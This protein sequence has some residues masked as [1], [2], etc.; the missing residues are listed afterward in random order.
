MRI[1]ACGDA[2]FSSRNLLERMPKELVRLFQDADAVF[3]NAEFCCPRLTTAPMPRRFTTAVRPEVLDEFVALNIKLLSFANNHTGD[4]GIQGVIDTLEEA[5]VRKLIPGGIGRSLDEARA[6]HFIDTP[7]GRIGFLAAGST[8][9]M[10][11]AASNPGNGVPARAGLNPLRWGRSYVL[12]EKEFNELRHIDELLGTA[13][14]RR[15]V[16]AVEVMKPMPEDR[17]AFGSVFEGSLQIV[18]GDEAEVRYHMDERDKEAILAN[19]RDAANR[20]EIA[21]VSLHTH[22]GTTENWYSPRTVSFVED[23]AHQAID[24]G[25]T[26]VLGH[27]PH[28]LRGVE[29]YKGK[30]IF[31]SLGSLLMEFETGSNIN[32]P[33]MYAGFGFGRD[34]LPSDLHMSRVADENGNKIGFYA[35]QR[36]SRSC[37]AILDIEDGKIEVS[38]VPIDLDLNRERPSQRGFPQIASAQLGQEIADDIAAMSEYYGTRI[39]F[40]AA[41]NLI[42]IQ[43]AV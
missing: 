20:S 31:Y 34:S 15:E 5:T 28:M 3:A 35:D 19:V 38:L 41:S 12:P 7:K 8:R 33:E 2:L 37:V 17:F 18:R 27:G 4:F 25:A 26:A 30:P 24:A 23:F 40:D 14:S 22:E 16:A 9:A 6:A 13:A 43:S 36:F 29:V 1:V 11:F 39:E 42:R 32:T 21:L 10:E